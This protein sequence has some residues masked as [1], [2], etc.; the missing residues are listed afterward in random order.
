MSS[1]ANPTHGSI[2]VDAFPE[3]LRSFI[4][5]TS[6]A[7]GCDPA[8]VALPVI[9]TTAAAIGSTCNTLV[10]SDWTEPCIIWTQVVAKSG[11]TKT[12]ACEAAT[13]PL[14]NL[15]A[16]EIKTASERGDN[17]PSPARIVSDITRE[18][19]DIVMAQNPRGVL[20]EADE[21]SSFYSGIDRYSSGKGSDVG[22]WLSLWSAKQVRRRRA[23]GDSKRVVVRDPHV[24]ITGCMTPGGLIDIVR[25][26]HNEDGLLARMLTAMPEPRAAVWSE[27]EPSSETLDAYADCIERLATLP[28]DQ[29][30]DGDHWP[31]Q[32]RLSEEAKAEFIPFYNWA[33]SEALK[34]DEGRSSM[35]GKV[36]GQALRIAMV[37]EIVANPDAEQISADSMQRAITLGRWFAE[38]RRQIDIKLK[39]QTGQSDEELTVWIRSWCLSHRQTG[40]TA[41][42]LSKARSGTFS[43]SAN[44]EQALDELALRKLGSWVQSV[45]GPGRKTRRF[46]PIGLPRNP[47]T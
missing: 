35:L 19:L 8:L 13:K 6:E 38:E 42:E 12:G 14:A 30:A 47:E 31:R 44:A 16:S 29:R 46:E 39:G 40:I 4:D 37:F 24:S 26:K 33:K 9:S 45:G 41:S 43:T 34:A 36:Y 3:P 7:I 23:T 2:P 20:L 22:R 10:K 32:L 25:S 11:S 18:S 15:E 28:R 27:R 21:V 17:G 5:E 1:E